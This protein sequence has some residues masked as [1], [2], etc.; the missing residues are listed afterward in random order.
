MNQ[1]KRIRKNVIELKERCEKFIEYVTTLNECAY[2][3]RMIESIVLAAKELEKN[4]NKKFKE[5]NT[6]FK[7]RW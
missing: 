2:S 1:D 7:E 3:D 6:N 5:I 4:H